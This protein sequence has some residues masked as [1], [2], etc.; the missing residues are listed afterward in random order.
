MSE[1]EIS[2]PLT[3][4]E[5]LR[6]K[7]PVCEICET[8]FDSGDRM[9]NLYRHSRGESTTRKVRDVHLECA[10]A[11]GVALYLKRVLE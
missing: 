5:L 10:R 9:L 4:T 6:L 2:D 8:P 3:A 11:V 7:Y 1:M